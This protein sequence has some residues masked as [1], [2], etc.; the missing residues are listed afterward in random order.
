ME[1][2][3][4]F[5][6]HFAGGNTYSFR[7]MYSFLKEFDIISLELPGRGKRINEKLISDFD[8]AALDV[9]DQLRFKRNKSNYIIFGH[10]MGASLALRVAG[11]MEQKQDAPQSIF[12]SGNPGPGVQDS[13]NR[14]LMNHED[15][16][17]E[18]K[19][20][21]GV[22]DELLNNQELFDFFEP[23][24][25]ADFE[26]AERNELAEDQPIATPIYAMMGSDEG[27]IDE[28][29]DWSRYTRSDFDYEIIEGDHFFINN[30]AAK[31]A[32]IIK[33]RYDH[34]TL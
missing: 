6:I 32:N 14:Y 27:R 2:T 24:L 25:R 11:L 17:N 15:F 1:K 10:S 29:T 19:K 23:I 8:A 33:T 7:F 20:L 3:Q 21:G 31:I 5:F 22:S 28:I 9:Y 13:R 18:L 26:I 16:V 12:V 34:V 30:H 4:L